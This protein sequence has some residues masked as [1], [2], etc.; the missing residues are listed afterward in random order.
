[1][2]DYPDISSKKRG[3][4]EAGSFSSSSQDTADQAAFDAGLS[5]EFKE[6]SPAPSEISLDFDD[7]QET[8][9]E[10]EDIQPPC[11]RGDSGIRVRFYEY[12]EQGERVPS[13]QAPRPHGTKARVWTSRA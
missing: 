5:D 8:T 3:L 9:R 11:R 6:E 7:A 12:N 2:A 10:T 13:Q 1:M 4:C